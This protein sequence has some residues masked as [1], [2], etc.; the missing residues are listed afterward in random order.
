MY[1]VVSKEVK[2]GDYLNDSSSINEY[3]ELGWEVLTT[4]VDV[5]YLLSIGYIKK[6]D[7][8]VTHSGREFLYEKLFNN[9]ITWNEF[10][11]LDK[12]NVDILDL[13]E[14]NINCFFN[15]NLPKQFGETKTHF[16]NKNLMWNGEKISHD[17]LFS[18]NYS[19]KYDIN[20]NFVCLQYR[21]RSHKPQRNIN[22]DYFIEI[23]NYIKS[24]NLNIY[25]VGYGAEKFID[26]KQIF[27]VDLRDWASLINNENCKLCLTTLS[28]PSHLIVFCA[29]KNCNNV[30]IDITN[31]LSRDLNDRLNHNRLNFRNIKIDYFNYLSIDLLKN[32]IK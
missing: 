15:D 14:N 26:N 29:N 27:Y 28:G 16:H 22:D 8:I 24:K 31:E 12:N 30:I 7:I 13:V 18:F 19:N 4:H 32:Y 2:H 20:E 6:D 21:K 23:I 25:I 17:I 11:K 10:E 3:F 5:K 9:V 1:I